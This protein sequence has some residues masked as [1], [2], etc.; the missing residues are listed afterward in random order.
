MVFKHGHTNSHTPKTNAAFTPI[1]HYFDLTKRKNKLN[2][3]TDE[4]KLRRKSMTNTRTLIGTKH[5]D[6]YIEAIRGLY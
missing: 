2:K 6:Q 4:Q 5:S 1:L 3:Q